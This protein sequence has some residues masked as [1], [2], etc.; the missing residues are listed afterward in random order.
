MRQRQGW[1]LTAGVRQRYQPLRRAG[2]I[3]PTLGVSTCPMRYLR[4]DPDAVKGIATQFPFRGEC[5]RNTRDQTKKR[6][7]TSLLTKSRSRPGWPPPRPDPGGTE[8]FPFRCTCRRPPIGCAARQQP[9]LTPV[10][11]LAG[12]AE[13]KGQIR[14]PHRCARLGAAQ[15][16]S[17]AGS[18]ISTQHWERSCPAQAAYLAR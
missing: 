12:A 5:E 1:L 18:P 15:L 4:W 11:S 6:T 16:S 7:G 14:Q 17:L 10:G 2:P 13:N 3:P 9:P 8:G